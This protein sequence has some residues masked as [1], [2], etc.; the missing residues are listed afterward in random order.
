MTFLTNCEEH[1]QFLLPAV[2]HLYNIKYINLLDYVLDS[3][4]FVY[5]AHYVLYCIKYSGSAER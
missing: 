3:T 2:F 1:L 5:L 4:T